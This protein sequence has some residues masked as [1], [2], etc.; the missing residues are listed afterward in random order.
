MALS[1]WVKDKMLIRNLK[2]SI[3]K[4]RRVQLDSGHAN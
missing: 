2:V 1:L 3:G 4:A